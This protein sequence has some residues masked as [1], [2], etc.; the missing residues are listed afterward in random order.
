M[1]FLKINSWP[2]FG[3]ILAGFWP[4][5]GRIKLNPEKILIEREKG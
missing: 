1:F 4:D 3:R 2:D 5:F